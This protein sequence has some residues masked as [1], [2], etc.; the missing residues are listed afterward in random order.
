VLDPRADHISV[1]LP[2]FAKAEETPLGSRYVY[3][4]TSREGVTDRQGEDIAADALW[5]SR[6]L[7]LTQ[8]N[9]DLNHW[10]WLGNPY[11]SGARPEYVVGAPLDV[12]RSGK[13]I[14]VKGEV[15]SN[16]RPP[17]ED[18]IGHHA[19]QLWHSLTLMRPPMRWWPSVFGT[20]KDAREEKRNGRTIRFMTAVEWYS[21]GFAQRAQHP[22]LPPISTS[23]EGPFAKAASGIIT[24]TITL[25][26]Y[27][28]FAKA[29]AVGA[30]V[31]DSA[32][33]TGVQALTPAS[34]EGARGYRDY[35]DV[36][37][38]VLD[39]ILKRVVPAKKDAIAKAFMNEGCD[40]F[41]AHVYAA[42]LLT[43]AG[44]SRPR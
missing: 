32:A 14:F 36:A 6:D 33:R 13:S 43:N 28:S 3:F 18:H 27:D 20:V 30:P 12:K 21:V 40:D 1:T 8:G 10:S 42:R 9:L 5:A 31:T 34:H 35:A 25:T 39:H 29:L 41:L 15:F 44:R 7:F 19:D 4:E 22:T 24:P 26:D 23:P 2:F 37:P 16:R 17:P 38:R 11:G